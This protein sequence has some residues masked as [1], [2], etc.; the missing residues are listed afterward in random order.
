MNLSMALLL[1]KQVVSMGVEPEEFNQKHETQASCDGVSAFFSSSAGFSPPLI[2]RRSTVTAPMMLM[3]QSAR[4][5][6][7]ESTIASL[8]AS[9]TAILSSPSK[10]LVSEVTPSV[11]TELA[12][13][14]GTPVLPKFVA[15]L[16]AKSVWAAAVNIAL[17]KGRNG[18]VCLYECYSERSK[19]LSPCKCLCK[20][21]HSGAYWDVLEREHVLRDHDRGLSTE[22][23]A[24][25]VN[26][27]VPD[28]FS[29]RCIEREQG[30]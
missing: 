25:A 7:H 18:L 14:P 28:P 26:N 8:S 27:L 21:Y 17:Q 2:L 30:E 12:S 15:S 1:N 3:Q 19:K 13:T 20:H 11:R 10:P 4:G 22:A 6:F 16:L 5:S 23:H 9:S 29:S 24:E